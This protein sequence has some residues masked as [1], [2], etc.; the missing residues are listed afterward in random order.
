MT[1]V[2][3]TLA[4]HNG[5]L[6]RN[7]G[8]SCARKAR[9]AIGEFNHQHSII[10]IFGRLSSGKMRLFIAILS[11]R[12]ECCQLFDRTFVAF[13]PGEYLAAAGL[14]DLKAGV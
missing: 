13:T 10:A 4:A 8:R 2:S 14:S 7:G 6:P 3:F 12:V 5:Q 11:R 1:T 9:I